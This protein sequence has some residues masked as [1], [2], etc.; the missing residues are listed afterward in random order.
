[1]MVSY[2]LQ[3]HHTMTRTTDRRTRR[4]PLI[5]GPLLVAVVLAAC[6]PANVQAGDSAG[7]Q[8]RA[9]DAAAPVVPPDGKTPALGG[10]RPIWEVDSATAEQYHA[11]LHFDPSLAQ[12]ARIRVSHDDTTNTRSAAVVLVPESRSYRLDEGDLRRGMRLVYA[13]ILVDTTEHIPDIGLGP[14]SRTAYLWIQGGP[15]VNDTFP[16]SYVVRGPDG[17]FTEKLRLL[18]ISQDSTKEADGAKK[19]IPRPRRSEV[20][21]GRKHPG[22]DMTLT[23]AEVLEAHGLRPPL[24]DHRSACFAC[25]DGWCVVTETSRIAGTSDG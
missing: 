24:V 16:A 11:Q 3:P 12:V 14:T 21:W 15:S 1:M 22:R 9:D 4:M 25:D 17:R 23:V 6:E 2:G 10:N 5:A 20:A 7:A 19:D 8:P 13:V 18:V